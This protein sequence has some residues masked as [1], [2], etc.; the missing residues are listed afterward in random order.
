MVEEKKELATA[1]EVAKTEKVE[2]PKVVLAENPETK[3]RFK[4]TETYTAFIG[5]TDYKFVKNEVSA[6]PKM[7]AVMQ[8]S[9]GKGFII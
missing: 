2:N 4:A 6:I 9:I 5:G 8:S 1:S 3:V 7:I